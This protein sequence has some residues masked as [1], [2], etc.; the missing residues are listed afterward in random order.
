[1]Q[2]Q[3]QEQDQ[4]AQQQPEQGQQQRLEPRDGHKMTI[5]YLLN[6]KASEALTLVGMTHHLLKFMPPHKWDIWI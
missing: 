1:M 5:G 6:G 3:E 2:Q 4:H